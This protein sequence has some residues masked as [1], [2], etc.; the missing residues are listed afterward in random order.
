MSDNPYAAPKA[1]VSD[2]QIQGYEDGAVVIPGG[3]G[4][5]VDRGV[6]WIAEGWRLFR[7]EIGLWIGVTVFLGVIFIFPI[8]SYLAGL[9]YPVF[10]AGLMKMSQ[11][12]WHGRPTNFGELFVGFKNRIGSLMLIT[13]VNFAATIVIAVIV[14]AMLGIGFATLATPE[15]AVLTVILGVL[16]VFA[17]M[18]PLYMAT[19]YAPAL[20]LLNDYDIGQALKDS[21]LGCLKNVF[22]LFVWSV[23]IFVLF[24]IAC[25]PVFLGL[26]ILMPVVFTSVY[27]SYRDIYLQPN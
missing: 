4:V 18:L 24:F 22:P 9:F 2:T 3:Q 10:N 25:M 20:I 15:Q 27:A 7:M 1:A 12:S 13:L 23:V 19:W 8:I 14:F 5:G 11:D 17:L 21:F 6:I 26:L 16:I